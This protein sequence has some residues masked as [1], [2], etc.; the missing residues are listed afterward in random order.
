MRVLRV[1][2]ERL[3]AQAYAAGQSSTT[4]SSAGRLDCSRASATRS[5]RCPTLRQQLLSHVP[6][7]PSHPSGLGGRS[8][9]YCVVRRR[10]RVSSLEDEKG[11]EHSG[12]LVARGPGVTPRPPFHSASPQVTPCSRIRFAAPVVRGACACR[13]WSRTTTRRQTQAGCA[14]SPAPTAPTMT[15]ALAQSPLKWA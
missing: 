2:R 1:R 11:V 14:S 8:R 6:P 3:N 10:Q 7:R 5:P 4:V 15:Y 12:R 9:P 13:V